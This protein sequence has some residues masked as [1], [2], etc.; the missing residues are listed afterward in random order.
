MQ[1]YRAFI[2]GPDGKVENCVELMC[3]NDEEAIRLAKQLVDGHDVEL[4]QLD[5]KIQTFR[6]TSAPGSIH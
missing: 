4:W 5:R 6:H 1:G 3:R 2:L